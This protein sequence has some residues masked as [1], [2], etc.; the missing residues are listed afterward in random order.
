[1]PCY[2]S[3]TIKENP[4]YANPVKTVT[5]TKMFYLLTYEVPLQSNSLE[6]L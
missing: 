3:Y 6:T 1:M 2:V 4:V 5:K